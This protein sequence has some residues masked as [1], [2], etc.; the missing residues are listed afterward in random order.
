MI[1]T[2]VGKSCAVVDSVNRS[3]KAQLAPLLFGSLWL[4]VL[5]AREVLQ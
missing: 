3:A 1:Y 5:N 4:H 2:R